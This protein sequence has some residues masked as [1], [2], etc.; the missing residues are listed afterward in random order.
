MVVGNGQGFYID[1]NGKI[2]LFTN[3]FYA[4]PFHNGLAL[5]Y[6]GDTGKWGFIDKIGNVAIPLEYEFAK[7]FSDDWALVAVRRLQ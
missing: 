2:V 1:K 5:V 3:F 6:D 4:G 7:S